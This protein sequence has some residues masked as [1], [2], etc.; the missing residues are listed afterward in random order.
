[1]YWQQDFRL[2]AST[3][4][5]E[6]WW[7]ISGSY[8]ESDLKSNLRNLPSVFM[9]RCMCNRSFTK[10]V[11]PPHPSLL[12]C[13]GNK[14]LTQQWVCMS[15]TPCVRLAV[16]FSQLVFVEYAVALKPVRIFHPLPLTTVEEVAGVGCNSKIQH[17][18]YNL[19]HGAV[20]TENK[21]VPVVI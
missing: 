9:C 11:N 3:V 4:D 7:R 1:M 17:L 13:A 8:H 21:F 5:A 14:F 2:Y 15:F 20:W 12:N 18:N 10:P 16:V 19:L 6:Q